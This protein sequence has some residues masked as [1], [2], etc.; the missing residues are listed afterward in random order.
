MTYFAADYRCPC[1]RKPCAP[2]SDESSSVE[3]ARGWH[4]TCPECGFSI[5]GPARAFVLD[6]LAHLAE[7]ATKLDILS[8]MATG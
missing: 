3:Y 8:G 7:R 4:A 5:S 1:C 2:I 6:A